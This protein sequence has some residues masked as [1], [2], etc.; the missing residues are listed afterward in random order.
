MGLLHNLLRRAHPAQPVSA[1]ALPQGARVG[2]WRV[3]RRLGAGGAGVVYLVSRWGRLHAL[4]LATRPGDKRLLREGR[5]LRRVKHRALVKFHGQGWWLGRRT[6]FPYLVMEYVEGLPLYS[7]ACGTNPTPRQLAGLLAQAAGALAALHREHALHRD[8]KGANTLVRP[9]GQELVLMDLGAGGYEGATPL[10]SHVLPPV[11]EVYLSPEAMAFA[12]AHVAQAG[13][14][15][16]ARP[17]DDLYALGV[18]AYRVLVDE[19]PF[20]V[21]LPRDMYWAAVQSRPAPQV[22]ERNPRVPEALAAIVQRL[23][24]SRPEERH[25]DA[26][27]LAEALLQAREAGGAEWELPVF[28]WYPEPGPASRTTRSGAPAGP[29]APGQEAALSLARAEHREQQEWMRLQR[30]VRR[31]LPGMEQQQEDSPAPAAPTPTARGAGWRGWVGAALAVAMLGAFVLGTT[32]EAVPASPTLHVGKPDQEVAGAELSP[33]ADPGAVA[34]DSEASTSVPAAPVAQPQE[35]PRVNPPTPSAPPS[36]QALPKPKRTRLAKTLPLCMGL[37][38]S[39]STQAL[40]PVPAAEECPRGAVQT[41]KDLGIRIGGISGIVAF[42]VHLSAQPLPVN[43]GP[44][45]LS[46]R[47]SFGDLAPTTEVHGRLLFG[48]DRIYGRFTVARVPDGQ[49]FPVCLDLYDDF[50]SK[51]GFAKW[52][53]STE[54]RVLMV[55]TVQ[56]MAVDRFK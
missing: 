51:R 52:P 56:L 37:A 46:L 16:Q 13:A 34:L 6:G 19:Y 40:N 35:D 17:T 31:R 23:L 3:V 28:E 9:G 26:Q 47:E 54:D 11:T 53:G 33:D 48:A 2:P 39:G 5:L 25:T 20:P 36:P 30:Q 1:S 14:R 32:L 7:W 41:M 8:V 55:S 44:F 45:T 27:E 42:A 10:T 38:C 4:K 29:V 50:E 15:Y 21:H 43:E 12:Q 49:T 18:M 22:R 24:A